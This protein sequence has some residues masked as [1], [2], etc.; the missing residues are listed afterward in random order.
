MEQ[1]DLSLRQLST[2]L[3]SNPPQERLT[4]T[5]GV[6][7]DSLSA[8]L[9]VGP[10]GTI[11][12]EDSTL[13]DYLMAFDHEKIPQRVVHAKGA[14]AKGNFEVT[15]D[16]MRK[17]C[18]AKLF[19]E[20]GKQTIVMVRFSTV[21]GD[22]GS[23][24]T[25][26]DPR[27]FAMKFYT[28]EGNWDLVANNTPIFFIR[29]PIL[30]PSFIHSQKRNPVTN[31]KDPNMFWDFLSLRPES[32]HQT[33]FLFTDRGIPDGYRFMNGYGSHTFKTVNEDG[34]AYYIKFHLKSNQGIKNLSLEKSIELAGADPDYSTR[35]LFNAISKGNFPTWTMFIQVMTFD[36]AE[37]VDF[38]PFDLTK[39]SI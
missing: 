15:T 11:S 26:R 5:N 16:E 13:F 39:V 12:Y 31:L 25:S 10:Y 17:V 33:T 30:F 34:I 7:L 36:Q 21:T 2:Y 20:I 6:P 4:S 37:A 18:K 14:G 19:N 28:E 9:T 29:D 38:N 35:D 8:S 32:I 1:K 23:P 24:D 3:E 22:V 27:G